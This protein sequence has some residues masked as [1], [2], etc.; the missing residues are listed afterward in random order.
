MLSKVISACL[1]SLLLASSVSA[2]N[3]AEKMFE[4]TSHDFGAVARGAKSDF[5]FKLKNVYKETVH[6]AGVRSSCGCTTPTISKDT[7]ATHETSEIIASLNT[8]SFLGNKS[9]TITVTFDQP[10]V[11]EVQLRVQGNIRGDVVI[12][13][14][15][16]QLGSVDQGA[17]SEQR[18]AVSYAGRSD[19]SIV[20]VQ[21]T[22]A[23]FEVEMDEISRGGGKVAYNLLVRLKGDA[24]S[25]YLN[26]ELVIVTNDAQAQR[27]PLAVEGR[28]VSD[29]TI[30]PA[31]LFLG[32]VAKG[33]TVTKKLV[34]RSSK[35]FRIL[36]MTCDDAAFNFEV[37]E[38]AKPVH[39]V[40]VTFVP[41]H[42]GK[43][44]KEIHIKTDREAGGGSSL[45]A[46]AIVS[47]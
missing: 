24:P 26:D 28:V 12:S 13:P 7:V 18:V 40:S 21:S 27:I 44:E 45:V 15:V 16:V 30:T 34:I 1:L 5:A 37:S 43:I 47:E 8:K 38:E 36:E 9:A 11:A 41:D 39:V 35:P 2:Q 23:H 31:S 10:F 46:H 22:N 17:T 14:G 25:G 19:W 3:W 4:V 33:Q 6:I 32:E 29:L 20:D 42:A